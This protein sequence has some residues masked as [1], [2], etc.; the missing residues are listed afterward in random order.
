MSTQR[1]RGRIPAEVLRRIPMTP[2]FDRWIREL[3]IAS[4]VPAGEIAIIAT[5]N[6][7]YSP[8]DPEGSKVW[9]VSQPAF[10][11]AI[12]ERRRQMEWVNDP[13]NY[14]GPIFRQHMSP[15]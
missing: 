15:Y 4:G 1:T 10:Q 2:E 3:A 13:K 5:A 9:T 8:D 14:W 12:R 6:H 11:A 7:T